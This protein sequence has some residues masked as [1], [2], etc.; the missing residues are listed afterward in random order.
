MIFELKKEV[1]TIGYVGAIAAQFFLHIDSTLIRL[2]PND[3]K[4]LKI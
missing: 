2:R 3:S 4:A 1:M